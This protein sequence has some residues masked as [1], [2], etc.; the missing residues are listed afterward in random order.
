MSDGAT[1][2]ALADNAA[3]F[4]NHPSARHHLSGHAPG[5]IWH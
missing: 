3:K 4:R 5:A 1:W 2:Q